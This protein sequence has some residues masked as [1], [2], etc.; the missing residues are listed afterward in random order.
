MVVYRVL[1]GTKAT[2]TRKGDYVVCAGEGPEWAPFHPSRCWF[3]RHRRGGWSGHWAQSYEDHPQYWAAYEFTHGGPA[4]R[5]RCGIAH[6][7]WAQGWPERFS[8]RG[9]RLERVEDEALRRVF[10]HLFL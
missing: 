10:E 7:L 3:L 1:R 4:F 5:A 9:L 6:G 2:A 8:Y